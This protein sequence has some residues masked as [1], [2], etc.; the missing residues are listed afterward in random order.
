MHERPAVAAVGGLLLTI[1][2]VSCDKRPTAPGPVRETGGAPQPVVQRI[3]L[4]GPHTVAPGETARFT[5]TEIRSDG[6]SRDISEGAS[7]ASSDT[8][9]LSIDRNGFATGIANGTA[10]VSARSVLQSRSIEVVVTPAGTYRL[11]GEVMEAGVSNTVPHADVELRG[12]G[13]QTQRATTS[14]LGT[15]TFF[16]VESGSQ[17]TVSHDGYMTHTEQL[18]LTSHAQLRIALRLA[19]ERANVEG[20]YTLTITSG[21]CAVALGA[22]T[23][24]WRRRTYTAEV[25]QQGVDVAVALSGPEFA[26]D[27]NKRANT[28]KGK[29]K[30]N[31]VFLEL[32]GRES[33]YYNY[34]GELPSVAEALGDDIF[35][36]TSGFADLAVTGNGMQGVLQGTMQR[37]RG[38]P[39]GAV[40]DL[41]QG[42]HTVVFAR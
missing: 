15:F 22:W 40:L 8:S 26:A 36:V 33:Y 38:V 34:Y 16:G 27:R 18:Q 5:V 17:I 4:A 23:D 3:D 2:A 19:G 35:F 7:W 10:H 31:R 39:R 21:P 24:E 6:T 9:V 30:G 12:P 37:M 14:S 28:F 29:V 20:T 41:C 32:Y 11:R 25:R 13:G 42:R 1:L